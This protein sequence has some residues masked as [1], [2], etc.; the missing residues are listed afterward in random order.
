MYGF[1]GLTCLPLAPRAGLPASPLR[2]RIT[3]PDVRVSLRTSPRPAPRPRASSSGGRT[4]SGGQATPAASPH[5]QLPAARPLA[6]HHVGGRAEE[7]VPQS[8]SGRARAGAP[9]AAP[10]TDRLTASS[11]APPPWPDLVPAGRRAVARLRDPAS[12]LRS[13]L[14]PRLGSLAAASLLPLPT[15]GSCGPCHPCTQSSAR[16]LW[17]HCSLSPLSWLSHPCSQTIGPLTAALRLCTEG[18]AQ[19]PGGAAGDYVKSPR[20][21]DLAVRCA[22]LSWDVLAGAVFALEAAEVPALCACSRLCAPRPSQNPSFPGLPRLPAWEN[23]A[24]PRSMHALTFP[25]RTW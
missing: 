24:S 6:S 5:P 22:P 17:H 2:G 16:F 7:A 23:V 15:P 12:C 13:V 10:Q 25:W 4:T 14:A 18:A 3:R 21:G 1:R 9:W 8:H 19:V 20:C 11:F